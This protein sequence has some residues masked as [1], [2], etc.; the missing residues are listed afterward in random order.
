M[1]K[2]LI[3]GGAGFIGKSLIEYY[4]KNKFNKIDIIDNFSRGKNDH[5][6][7]KIKNYKNIRIIKIDL[8]LTNKLNFKKLHTNYDYI[9]QLAA[10]LGVKNV[11]DN[12]EVVLIKNLEIQKN[13]ILIAKEQKK[14]KKF[15]FFSTSEVHIG[16]LKYMKMKFPTK[17]FF[18]IALDELNN[19]R[20]SYS[21]SKI[22]GEALLHH[23]KIKYLILRPYNIYGPRM[24]MSHVIPQVLKKIYLA[25]K[26]IDVFSPNH[27]RSFCFID[28]AVKQ[29]INLT[30]KKKLINSVHNIGNNKEEIKIRNLIKILKKISNKEKL[31]VRYINDKDLNSP[32]RRLPHINKINMNNHKFTSL[33]RGCK[34]TYNWYLKNIFN[35]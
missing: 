21:L 18:P 31:K 29:I 19:P 23:S 16:S 28:D 34:I 13:S 10:I 11:I 33:H 22:Y 6:I 30:H 35:D 3:I 27:S 26:S 8:S 5:F 32:H 1:S 20:T 24:G 17:E 15:I 7:K 9:Y 4:I 2:I 14:L 25:K 12:P